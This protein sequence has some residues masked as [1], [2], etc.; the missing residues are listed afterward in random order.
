VKILLVQ[1][2]FLGDL[3]LSTPVIGGLLSKHPG[4]EIYLM[5]TLL[6]QALVRKDRRIKG[7]ITFDKK[8]SEKGLRGFFS[9]LKEVKDHKF[10]IVY[11]LHK[12]YRTSIL[13]F[14]AQIPKRVGFSKAHLSFLYTDRVQRPPKEHDVLRNLSLIGHIQEFTT[15][16]ME[17]KLYGPSGTESKEIL[18]L[19]S[20]KSPYAV[21]APGSAW[22][23]KRWNAS[24][25]RE[26]VQK[27]LTDFKHD[28]VVVGVGSEKEIADQVAFGTKAHN[29]C[30]KTDLFQL[31]GIVS[32]ASLMVCN[33]SMN[34]HLASA[35][36]I[37]T[38]TIFCATSPDF[39]FGPWQNKAQVIEKENLPCKPCSRHGGN[40]CPTGTELCMNGIPT[41]RVT[42]AINQ[43]I[44]R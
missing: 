6:G 42:D 17:L 31:M 19:F 27:L 40:S 8:K 3:I 44:S 38:V 12:S 34:L 15:A 39:G 5:T 28:V 35:F 25:Y 23:T 7:V 9:K 29:L 10:D 33:D 13:L 18:D 11:S 2:S 20:I 30:G 26:I 41:D 37:P 36:K 32:N 22:A 1:T 21:I 24:G 43:M 16:E 14:L 4:A